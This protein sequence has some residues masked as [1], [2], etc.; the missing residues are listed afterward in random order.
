MSGEWNSR[1]VEYA[2]RAGKSPDEMLVQD[3]EKWPGGCMC[4][5]MCWISDMWRK[6]ERIS[7]RREPHNKQD[8][9]SFDGWLKTGK[10]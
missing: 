7:G 1:Y 5:F 10:L 3:E 2:K 9:E 8:H 4:G 6:W